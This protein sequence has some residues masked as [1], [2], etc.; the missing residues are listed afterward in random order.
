MLLPILAAA[1][2]ARKESAVHIVIGGQTDLVYLPATL[3]QQLGHYE[4]NGIPVQLEDTGAGS[5]SLQAVLG[6][7]AQIAAGFFDHAV[8]MAADGQAVKAFVCLTRYPG[9]V[10]VASPEGAKRIRT[11]H[12]LKGANVGVT[13]PGSSSHFFLNTLLAQNGLSPNDV[14]VVAMGGGRSR[15]AAIENNKV[16]AGVLFEPGVTFL[17][18]RAP[19]ARVLIDTRTPEGVKSVF[20]AAE[21]PSSVLYAKADWLSANTDTARKIARA[22]VQTLRWIQDHSAAQVAERMP[23]AFHS[24]DPAAY[25]QALETSRPMYSPNGVMRAEAAEAVKRVLAVSLEKVRRANVDVATTYTNEFL[26]ER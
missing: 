6:G 25:G 7:S 3:A 26:S 16:D 21:Y 13:A 24:E 4:A 23:A 12:D 8:Q 11:I 20:G 14:S 9:A 15:V 22:M 19:G 5:K 17:L 2:C 18:R 1:G 10:L